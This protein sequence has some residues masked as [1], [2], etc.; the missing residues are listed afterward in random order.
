MLSKDSTYRGRFAPSPTGPLHFGSLYTAVASYLQ[1]KANDGKWLLRIDDLDSFRCKAEYTNKILHTL[2]QYQ[3]EWDESV[4][5][6]RS[7]YDAYQQALNTLEQ[8]NILYP[9]QCSR[10]DLSERH[11]RNGIYDGYCLNH[12]IIPNKAY[13][14]RLKL[15][16]TNI[17]FTDAVQGTTQQRLQ[18]QVG[19]F[20]MFRKDEIHAYHLAVVLDDHEQNITQVL[21][22]YDLLHSTY[23][24]IFLQ[25]LLNIPTPD[26]AHIP[27]VNGPGG[28][29]LS[30]QTFAEDVSLSPVRQTL[31][32]VLTHLSLKPPKELLTYRPHEILKWAVR[33][34]SLKNI[35]PETA[36]P[37][38]HS[39]IGLY[40]ITLFQ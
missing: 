1:A 23:R 16:Q 14:V 25:Q 3:L 8:Q 12:P 35:S 32:S 37:F 7:R 39:L 4:F 28:A 11:V 2:E 21:R 18:A 13:S 24:Q 27:V 38:N 22:G 30:K 20:I 10:K 26:Y 17:S 34:W 31:I 40:V 9:C 19:D 33:H 6:Q 29:K 15:P 5:Y 36:I